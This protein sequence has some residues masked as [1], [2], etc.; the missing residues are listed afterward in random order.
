MSAFIGPLTARQAEI[1]PCPCCGAFANLEYLKQVKQLLQ[2]WHDPDEALFLPAQIRC[3]SCGLTM[4]RMANKAEN[5]GADGARKK[6]RELAIEAWNRR[7][8]S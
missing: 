7:S 1:S 4:F 5:G 8:Q 3:T 2:S 6:V